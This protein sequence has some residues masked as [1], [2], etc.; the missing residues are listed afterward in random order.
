LSL[1][2]TIVTLGPCKPD[3]GYTYPSDEENRRFS[4][5]HFQKVTKNGEKFDRK[6][7]IYSKSQNKA[8]CFCCKLYSTK[9]DLS[10]WA[11]NGTADWKHISQKIKYHELSPQHYQCI[12]YWNEA[13]TRLR[14]GKTLDS[15]HLQ[16]LNAEKRHWVAVLERIIYF[17]QFLAENNLAFRGHSSSKLYQPQN[18]NFL[19]LVEMVAKFDPIMIEHVRRIRTDQIHDHYLGHNI[20]NELIHLLAKKIETEIVT[21]IKRALYFGIILDC[22]PDVSKHEQMTM[23]LRCVEVNEFNDVNIKE[24]FVGFMNVCDKTGAGLTEALKEKLD[25]LGIELKNCRS[26]SYDN[27]A[28]MRG[29]HQGVQARVLTENP[30]AFFTPCA[31]H[32]LNLLLCDIAKCLPRGMTFFGTVQKIYN[33]FAGSTN[34]WDILLEHVDITVKSLSET[35]WE[36]RIESIKPLRYKLPQIRDALLDV[37]NKTSSPEVAATAIGLVN[38]EF[39]SYE[40]VVNIVIW[41]NLL[42]AINNVSKH[43]QSESMSLDIAIQQLNGLT[44]FFENY[45][46]SGFESALVDAKE[47]AQELEIMTEFKEVRFCRK[48][49]LFSYESS[50]EQPKLNP[51]ESFKVN[52]FLV[53]ID[54]AKM[55]IGE[56]LQQIQVFNN[57]FGFIY[58]FKIL[59]RLTENELQK[60]CKDLDMALSDGDDKDIDVEELFEELKLFRCAISETATPLE[61]LKFALKSEGFYNVVIAMRIALTIGITVASAERSFSVL[62]LIKTYSRST[63]TQQRLSDLALI[64]IESEVAKSLKVSDIVSVFASLK[65][66]KVLF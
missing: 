28:N 53:L 26:Q 22:T 27:G 48:K 43:L 13:S 65:A 1:R 10:S 25:L 34:S 49:R 32:N 40:F 46:E 2:D 66:R 50:D 16:L 18:G 45:R 19:G 38:N 17:I 6:W 37:A 5:V 12:Q 41:Y 56:R 58:N 11:Y 21:K 14:S 55:S 64:S 57:L 9:N 15:K 20:Q 29:K 51:K 3:I 44:T 62:K 4:N 24:Y 47:I 61:A 35:R 7:L 33:V 30:R 31:T 42:F 60:H 36:S 63:M 54:T 52:Y 8:Y 39:E 59:K 23:I